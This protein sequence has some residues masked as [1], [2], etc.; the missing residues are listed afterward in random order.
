MVLDFIL[1][2]EISMNSWNKGDILMATSDVLSVQKGDLLIINQIDNMLER[3]FI[4]RIT[5]NLE[6]ILEKR[7]I[8]KL[9]SYDF[10]YFKK[11]IKIGENGKI[12]ESLAKD[13]YF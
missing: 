3:Y 11:F 7:N 13:L 1:R 8:F 6:I 2:N 10:S 5:P 4:D 9:D 12:F